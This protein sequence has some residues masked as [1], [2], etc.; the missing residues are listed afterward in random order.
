M[1]DSSPARPAGTGLTRR[2][3]LGSAATVGALTATDMVL[4]ANLRKAIAEPARRGGLRDIEH[5]V[6]L[7]QENRSFDHY[8]GTLSG[9]RG[10]DDPKAARLPNGDSVFEQP[11]P[12]SPAGRLLPYRL[13]TR[14][15][16]AQVIPSTSHE[17]AVQHQALNGGRMDQWL[18]AHRAADGKNGPY[19]MGYFTREDIPFQYALA[20]AFTVLDHYHC[21]VLGPTGPNRHM[22]LAGTVDPD[23]V[24]GGPSL[25]TGAP[26]G[27][28]SFTTYPERLTDH[29]VSWKFYHQDGATGLPTLQHIAQYFNARPGDPLHDQAMAS[30]PLGQ[31]EYDALNDKL[32]TVSWILPPSGFDE[33]PSGSPAAGAAFVSGIIDALASNP[34][35]W[36]KTVFILSYDENDGMFDHVVPPT[37]PAGTAGE[38]VSKTSATGVDGGGLPVGL[39]FRVPAIIVSP[40]TVGGWVCSEVFDHT[41]QLRFLER[42]T[43]VR[44]PN[45]S[46]WRRRTVGDLTSAFRFGDTSRKIPV[47]PDTN[48]RLNLSKYQ[49]TQFPLPTAPT[50]GQHLPGQEPGSRPHVS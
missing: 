8:F 5:V 24:A 30:S 20:D 35:V 7:M 36:A 29:G 41:S 50:G 3:I 49:S 32:P 43:G 27:Q 34:D 26:N 17:W 2:R 19:V 6:L 1:N 33:H 13:D 44:E 37:P 25:T 48:G 12:A 31:F 21:S 14:T 42:V 23:G 39:G 22:W 47:L 38:F 11:D 18:P 28:Y 45:I 10:F 9:V 40:W 15:T 16:A 4:P 46:S